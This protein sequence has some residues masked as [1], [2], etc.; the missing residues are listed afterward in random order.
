M[1]IIII[2]MN[3]NNDCFLLLLFSCV[4]TNNTASKVHIGFENEKKASREN[5]KY[6]NN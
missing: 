6:N 2:N 4:D 3:N 5:S 1:M